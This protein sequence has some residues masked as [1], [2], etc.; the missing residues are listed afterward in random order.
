MDDVSATYA[1]GNCSEQTSTHLALYCYARNTA[2]CRG[3]Q[4]G[5]IHV[6]SCVELLLLHASV[7][8]VGLVAAHPNL[9][10][11]NR[12]YAMW[13]ISKSETNCLFFAQ[14]A[15]FINHYKNI[16]KHP[17]HPHFLISTVC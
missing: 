17:V 16:P 10:V 14:N 9:G 3:L 7:R 4:R 15:R 6:W 11:S 12:N 1:K 5:L 8:V 13:C 2:T